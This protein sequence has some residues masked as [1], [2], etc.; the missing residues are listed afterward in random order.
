MPTAL[1]S[2]AGGIGDL[3]RTTPLVGVC[4]ALGFE[5]DLLVENDYGDAAAL[6]R[7]LPGIRGVFHQRSRWTG[8]GATDLGDL[9][10]RTYDLALFT[11]LTGPQPWIRATRVIS[12]DRARW[13]TE[14]DVVSVRRVATELGWTEALPSP[15]VRT[16][17]RRFDL[18]QRTIAIHPGCKP[19]WPWK[20]WHGFPDLASRLPSIVLIGMPSDLD[21]RDTYF[22]TPFEWPS[23]VRNFV[24]QLSLP[25]TAAL[26]SEC[27]A[28]VSNDSGLMHVA[29]ALGIPTFGIFG[30]TS[31]AREA[32][33]L[34]NMVP[35]T[36]GLSCEPECR[37]RPWGRS[38]CSRHL[39][40]LRSLT[41]EDV[42]SRIEQA[43][44]VQSVQ[45]DC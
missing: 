19:N 26:I 27:A 13:L 29:A 41:A 21:N 10:N 36:K 2:A 6:V 43:L 38:D 20:K 40:C 7:D 44:T 23:H 11:A 17:G 32:L 45:R 15:M 8:A 34:P 5:I 30:I 25:D 39:E 18:E 28:L 31:P 24:G 9:R 12:I 4:H 35:V 14:G 16:S 42:M 33:P 1:I 22:G 3:V 37:R